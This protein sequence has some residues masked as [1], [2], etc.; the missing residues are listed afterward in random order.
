MS[1]LTGLIVPLA[2]F[3]MGYILGVW[4]LSKAN[5]KNISYLI[6]GMSE[7]YKPEVIARDEYQEWQLE[8]RNKDE[9][10]GLGKI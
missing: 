8:Q 3:L 4:T 6:P 2:M 5:G 7:G 9:V 10:D 1:E